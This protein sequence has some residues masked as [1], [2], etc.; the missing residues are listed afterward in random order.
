MDNEIREEEKSVIEIV[1]K[2]EVKEETPKKKGKSFL[3]I[4]F[5]I[6]LII[7][8]LLVG[9]FLGKSEDK[10][11]DENDKNT[12][13]HEESVGDEQDKNNGIAIDADVAPNT[14]VVK[15][16]EEWKVRTTTKKPEY[17]AESDF[18]KNGFLG[19]YDNEYSFGNL[20]ENVYPDRDMGDFVSLYECKNKEYGK[21]GFIEPMGS[22]GSYN[23][24]E[25]LKIAQ[26]GLLYVESR[27]V[28][29]YDG[30]VYYE[31]ETPSYLSKESPL[32]IYDTIEKK[33]LGRYSAVYSNEY[34][35]KQNIFVVVDF[36]NN[37]S[38]IKLDNGKLEVLLE[39]DYAYIGHLYESSQYML[40]KDNQFYVYNPN[41]K[42]TYGPYN[43]QVASYS[44]KHIVTNE[45]S[46]LDST[47]KNYRLYTIDGKVI[48]NNTG[49]KYVDLIGDYALVI[50]ENASLQIYDANGKALLK[51]LI[52]NVSGGAYHI[53]CCAAFM[54]YDAELVGNKLIF[55]VN[56]QTSDSNYYS[57]EYT[58]DLTTGNYTSKKVE[59]DN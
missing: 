11:D 48:V 26:E 57:M 55:N 42:K 35:I 53:R 43:N 27:Y 52:K 25:I 38:L 9:W 1:E 18:Y 44:E 2:E 37:Y 7:V 40:V 47:E 50:D 58:I 56:T 10:N 12:A 51:D 49:N 30:N 15:Q 23:L 13:V 22:D 3:L 17:Y 21:C 41:T 32:I 24:E 6:I 8:A 14:I 19:Y 54:A 45:G 5:V 59:S 36:D 20:D 39:G 31:T 34:S 33:E 4:V 29:V 16:K 46:Y 28:F